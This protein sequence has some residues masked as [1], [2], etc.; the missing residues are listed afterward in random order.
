M[1]RR[2]IPPV[3]SAICQSV[4]KK[5]KIFFSEFK[6]VYDTMKKTYSCG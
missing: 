1:M 2:S 3:S 4:N 5:L 6:K